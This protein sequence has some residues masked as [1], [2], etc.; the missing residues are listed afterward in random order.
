MRIMTLAELGRNLGRKGLEL[1]AGGQSGDAQALS[2]FPDV[3]SESVEELAEEGQAFEAEAICALEDS[4][5]WPFRSRV[6]RSRDPFPSIAVSRSRTR[7]MTVFERRRFPD[8]LK[9][10]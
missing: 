5:Q 9:A 8:R 4:A 7:T 2:R 6:H 10:A 1:R 3:D